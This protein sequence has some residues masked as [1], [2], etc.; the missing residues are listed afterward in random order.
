[1]RET[2]LSSEVRRGF[3]LI[4]LLIVIFI[5]SLVYFLGFSTVKKGKESA[6]ALSPETL[7]LTVQQSGIREG[8]LVCTKNCTQCFFRTNINTAFKPYNGK[9][10]L[11][12]LKV[13]T[14]DAQGMLVR[15]EP[16]QYKHEKICLLMHF[17]PNGSST[18]LIVEQNDQVF[19]L[20]SYF[21]SPQK[22][23]SL[24]EAKALWLKQVERLKTFGAVY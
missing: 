4:E 10:D 18:P 14:L 9:L 5:V 16:G 24:E 15:S 22:A 1:M 6:K 20:P 7:K 8:T 3:S 17:Y 11:K 23:T 12:D 19:F 2:N 13:Y 21:G